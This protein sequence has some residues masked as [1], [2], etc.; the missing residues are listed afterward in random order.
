MML[1][2]R[3]QGHDEDS[4]TFREVLRLSEDE[5]DK[6]FDS[7]DKELAGLNEKDCFHVVDR[8]AAAGREIVPS[9]WALK[10]KRRPNGSLIKYK[11]R[12]TIRGDRQTEGLREGEAAKDA[13]GYAPVIDWGTLRMLLA[14]SVQHGMTT[15][16][17]DFKQAFIQAP[18]DR[19][20]FIS[21]PPGIKE[22]PE[23]QGKV[24]KVTQSLYGHRFGAKLF[25][26]LL[27]ERLGT[28]GFKPSEYDPC[29]FL[30]KDCLIVTW[31]D[32]A[33]II[34][35]DHKTAED[36]F[37][38]VKATGFD[39]D[40]EGEHGDLAGYL[41]IDL[42][43]EA[44]GSIHMTQ[45]G[46]IERII[47]ALGLEAANPKHTPAT[48]TLGR[49]LDSPQFRGTFNYRSV[50]GMLM[51]LGNSTRP[52]ISLAVH[53]CARYSHDPREAHAK[54]LKRIGHY[55]LATRTQGLIVKPFDGIPR[56]DCYADA[57]FAGLY[58]RDDPQDPAGA[59]SRTGF[60]I[61]LGKNPI[62]WKSKLQ[63]E[64]ATS[65]MH[66]EYVAASTAMRSLVH[67][68]HVH[69]QIVS[70]LG[71]PFDKKSNISLVFEDNQACLSL[72]TNDPP[73]MTPQSRRLQSSIIGSANNS[74]QRQ[75]FL[76]RSSPQISSPTF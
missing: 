73:R 47:E 12:L 10:K 57:D 3:L 56:L 74:H 19:P 26:E 37:Q 5:R 22:L 54:A 28:I 43:K 67:L 60:V 38:Q 15:M 23:Y 36:V 48:E 76:Q 1:Q 7:M 64:T 44:D 53:Q 9:T 75:L 32:D 25:Y 49:H 41:G 34:A 29:L 11:S 42:G 2:A 6:W 71:L 24:L 35:R 58:H 27:V 17:V 59:R 61:T 39:L 16:Q 14:L 70:T 62:L 63:T 65:T 30:G 52:D 72:A 8:A 40:K 45:T 69:G 51:Y 13:S 20:M 46:L 68:R 21:L 33:I 18:L 4:P 55:L 50:V 66:A 31:V